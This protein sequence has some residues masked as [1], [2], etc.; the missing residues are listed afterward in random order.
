MKLRIK[1]K[2]LDCSI[3]GGKS[4]KIY[5][6]DLSESESQLLYDNGFSYLFDE[7][8]PLK[9]VED[10]KINKEENDIN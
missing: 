1:K 7:I 10:I 3:A 5:L 6:I 4:K 2:Y 8:K 9:V